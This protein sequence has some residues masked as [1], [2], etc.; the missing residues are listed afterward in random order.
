MN[1]NAMLIALLIGALFFLRRPTGRAGD[2]GF[3]PETAKGETW[4][5]VLYGNSA[6]GTFGGWGEG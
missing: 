1:Q 4:K 2:P 5:P 6:P 3:Y